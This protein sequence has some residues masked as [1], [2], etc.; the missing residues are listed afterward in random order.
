MQIKKLLEGAYPTQFQGKAY[1]P[2]KG[3]IFAVEYKIFKDNTYFYHL[4]A[5][6]LN[7][8]ITL[9]V[10]FIIKN[11]T[12]KSSLAFVGSLIFGIH[13]VHTE[14][15]TFMTAS[16]DGWGI[17]FFFIAFYL[18][19][20]IE[21]KKKYLLVPSLLF[22]VLAFFTYELTLTLPLIL[23]LY[24]F[25]FRKISK[26][27]LRE[28]IAVYSPY[29]VLFI[30]FFILRLHFIGHLQGGAYFAGSFYLTML[31]M[32]KAVV[33][34]LELFIF[35]LNLSINP[36][37]SGGIQSYINNFTNLESIKTQSLFNFGVISS[38]F[39]ILLTLSV[40]V[41]SFRKNP[42]ICFSILFF[43]VSL[44]PILNIIPQLLIMAERY[45]YIAS[46]G[47]ALLFAY[48]FNFL[49]NYKYKRL[50]YKKTVQNTLIV[51]L[52]FIV[53]AF[54][55]LTI[56]RNADWK[57]DISVWTALANQPVSNSIK[58]AYL[59]MVYFQTGDYDKAALS[60]K[61]VVAEKGDVKFANY[62]LTF[63]SVIKSIN[64]G[65]K[66]SAEKSY[67]KLIKLS[68]PSERGGLY[69]LKGNIDN[70]P[71]LSTTNAPA[72]N[73][74]LKEF[75]SQN[76]SFNYPENWT[77]SESA[78]QTQIQSPDK[79]FSIEITSSVL[80]AA[81]S[82]SQYISSQ[83]K[84]YGTLTNQGLAKIPTVDYAYVKVW[85]DNGVQKMQFF[86]FKD[87]DVLEVIV[88]PADSSEMREFDNILVSLKFYL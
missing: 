85:N 17:L 69:G 35:P 82:A 21:D 57:D 24:D 76:F 51:L 26:K 36:V 34:Y 2:V 31:T 42:L 78:N 56:R 64:Q 59:G 30:A 13:P 38:V 22:A 86:L 72:N 63:I 45:E 5:I 18:Y 8:F 83:T 68:L 71:A 65:D 55:V 79:N 19:L 7:L 66:K 33:K 61:K 25:C 81:T 20:R 14:A 32:A 88:Y 15:I 1:R 77:L 50:G 60:F 62:F 80:P 29:F 54:S 44:L 28:R 41:S 58:N 70:I 16:L 11:I 87:A 53:A 52:I 74:S 10:Y 27:N 12:R 84:V 47:G 40:A 48:L 4:Q 37:L 46:F 6:I 73:R 9:L 67:N 3:V 23:V 49:Y 39:I 43:Y 75:Q